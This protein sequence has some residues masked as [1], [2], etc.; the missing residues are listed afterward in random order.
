M[1]MRYFPLQWL[2][3]LIH[4]DFSLSLRKLI[5]C[6]GWNLVIKQRRGSL[7]DSIIIAS[8]AQMSAGTRRTCFCSTSSQV[9][10]KRWLVGE[11]G[12]NRRASQRELRK[13]GITSWTVFI[14]SAIPHSLT[15]QREWARGG[16]SGENEVWTHV[17]VLR[18]SVLRWS[19]M[20]G[21]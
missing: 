21:L 7:F 17:R 15:W 11:R 6:G 14:H 4:R 18:L 20:D 1:H 12:E 5:A 13:T 8:A 10:L 2:M 16:K 9:H 3:V 19:L